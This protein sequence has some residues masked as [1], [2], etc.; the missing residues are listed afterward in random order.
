MHGR[1]LLLSALSAYQGLPDPLP[2]HAVC[3]SQISD[4]PSGE[5]VP[6]DVVELHSGDKVPADIR[7]IAL[8]TATVRAEQSSLTG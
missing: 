1:R 2:L 7:V 3:S 6:G 4:L 5:L 8:R